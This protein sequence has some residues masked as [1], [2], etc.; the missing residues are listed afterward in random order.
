MIFNGLVNLAIMG[1]G[2]WWLVYFAMRTTRKAF[3]LAAAPS[4][5]P[6]TTY[7][8]PL[9]P[10]ASSTYQV[11]SYVPPLDPGAP[12]APDLPQHQAVAPIE[13][14]SPRPLVVTVIA[15]LLILGGAV[16]LPFAFLPFPLFVFGFPLTGWPAHLAIGSFAVIAVLTGI[17]LWRLE[18][19][20]FYAAC[21][22]Y[23]FGLF[24]TALLLLPSVRA[25]MIAYQTDLMQRMSGGIPKPIVFDSHM[26]TLMLIP[27]LLF[28]VVFCVVLLILLVRSRAAFDRPQPLQAA[29]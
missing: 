25:R 12:T 14:P 16:T 7:P 15:V 27:G 8:A 24:N 10:Y 29:A 21:A 22:F 2:I 23:I 1:I 3:E 28:S 5:A 6:V 13:A 11:A 26:M 17:G 18:K 20:A 9:S 4:F 19:I